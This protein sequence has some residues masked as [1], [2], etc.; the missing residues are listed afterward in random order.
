M[1]V[2]HLTAARIESVLNALPVLSGQKDAP[3]NIGAGDA[4]LPDLLRH[5]YRLMA[6]AHYVRRGGV[7]AMIY[8][9]ET[10]KTKLS[11][12]DY[13]DEAHDRL[14]ARYKDVYAP[15][16]HTDQSLLEELKEVSPDEEAAVSEVLPQ[17]DAYLLSERHKNLL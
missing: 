13:L 11:P 6:I 10:G 4:G 12:T 14:L 2:D 15:P 7:Q 5:Y 9:L 17:L 8:R 16:M 3:A 1:K